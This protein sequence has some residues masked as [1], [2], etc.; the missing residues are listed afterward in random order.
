MHTPWLFELMMNELPNPAVYVLHDGV[1]EY[2]VGSTN[3]LD[4]RVQTHI[5]GNGSNITKRWVAEGKQI[6]PYWIIK[7]GVRVSKS[8]LCKF[9]NLVASTLMKQ[10]TKCKIYG[11]AICY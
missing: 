4:A 11:G 8:V 1:D 7:L 2:Y 5:D 3:N 6:R 9:E 10:N